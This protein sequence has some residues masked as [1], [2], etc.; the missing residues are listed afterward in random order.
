MPMHLR[1]NDAGEGFATATGYILLTHGPRHGIKLADHPAA[2][3]QGRHIRRLSPPN[4]KIT[5]RGDYARRAGG[6]EDLPVLKHLLDGL[7]EPGHRDLLVISDVARLFKHMTLEKRRDL[8]AALERHGASIYDASR[9]CLL[10]NMSPD[11]LTLLQFH[12]LADQSVRHPIRGAKRRT[13]P[14]RTAEAS[15]KSREMR[16]LQADQKAEALQAIRAEMTA[17]HGAEPTLTAVANEANRRGLFTTR[18]RP[19]T[20]STVGRTLRRLQGAP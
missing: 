11:L 7:A 8:R 2:Q 14:G 16:G 15:T 18:N 12:G 9:G 10:K 20:A 4:V 5:W 1:S 6:L 3:A 17:L 13:D 19:W